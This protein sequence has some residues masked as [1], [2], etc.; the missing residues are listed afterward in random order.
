MHIRMTSEKLLNAFRLVSREIVDND[1]N[2]F[3]LG[4]GGN[5][6]SQKGVNAGAKPVRPPGQNRYGASSEISVIGRVKMARRKAE[7]QPLVFACRRPLS[8]GRAAA[9]APS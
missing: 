2:L 7:R 5:N 4:L 8:W 9:V 6:V 3:A 1:V